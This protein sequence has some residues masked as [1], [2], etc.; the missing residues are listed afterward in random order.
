[1]ET[2]RLVNKYNNTGGKYKIS[3][4]F[5]EIYQTSM[6]KKLCLRS[7]RKTEVIKSVLA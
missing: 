7:F 3:F 1:M 2:E 6:N 4:G 5:K